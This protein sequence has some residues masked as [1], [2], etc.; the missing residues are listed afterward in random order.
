VVVQ[1]KDG[2]KLA[3]REQINRGA[4]NRPLSN[5]EIVA[6]FMDNA[7]LAVSASRAGE[8]RDAILAMDDQAV[9]ASGLASVLGA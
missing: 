3:H 9:S 2:R 1:L 8:M 6:K 5:E 7:Q 4:P